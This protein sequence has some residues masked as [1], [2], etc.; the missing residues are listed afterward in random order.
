M[1]F[2][3]F[4]STYTLYLRDVYHLSSIQIGG[5]FAVN[6]LVIVAAEML[7]IDFV[8]RWPLVR[9]IGWG[10]FF[11]CLGFGLLPFGSTFEFA[12]VAMLV[13]TL[14]E[15]LSMP[16]AAGFVANR[17]PAGAEGRYMGWWAMGIA[18]A[19]VFGPMI[20]GTLYQLDPHW[21]WYV[22]LAVGVIV[23]A[24]F[25]LLPQV[26]SRSS[27]QLASIRAVLPPPEPGDLLAESASS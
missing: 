24:G 13:M 9:T 8:K 26:D 23:L 1:V 4:V 2:F 17:A 12:I 27:S 16:L 22:S 7:L 19:F 15:M 20:G 14:G 5:L 18:L 3:Q 25:Y 11:S 6:T 21:V 10:C